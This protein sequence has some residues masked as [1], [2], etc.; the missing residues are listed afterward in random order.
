MKGLFLSRP[1]SNELPSPRRAKAVSFPALEKRY[2]VIFLFTLAISYKEWKLF[3]QTSIV[4]IWDE[5]QDTT[6]RKCDK[7]IY[8]RARI[9]IITD[10]KDV[11][12]L[13]AIS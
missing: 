1:Y 3:K 10:L 8:K 12:N 13:H 6:N 9:Y 2:Q 7:P 4:A 5:S 11:P